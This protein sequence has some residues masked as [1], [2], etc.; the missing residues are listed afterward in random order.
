MHCLASTALLLKDPSDFDNL[1]PKL[2]DA[3]QL[4]VYQHGRLKAEGCLE[5][6]IFAS[7]V[8][9]RSAVWLATRCER[10]CVPTSASGGPDHASAAV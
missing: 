6:G 2:L 7:S 5:G 4:P 3:A 1:W 10:S 9:E 8:M